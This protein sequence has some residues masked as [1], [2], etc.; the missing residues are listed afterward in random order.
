MKAKN[1]WCKAAKAQKEFQISNF[2]FQIRH[3]IAFAPLRLCVRF[4]L[5]L[6]VFIAM[7]ALAAD[8]PAL[9]DEQIDA[10]VARGVDFLVSQQQTDGEIGT[11]QS[12]IATSGLS[13]LALLA[14]GNTP[15]VGRNGTVVRQLI[16]YLATIEPAD[17]YFGK[18]DGSR[19]YGQGIVTLALAEALGVETTEARR[20]R[21]VSVLNSS[22]KV[23]L[24]AQNVPKAQPFAGGWRYEPNSTDSDLSQAAWNAMALRACQNAGLPVPKSAVARAG[25]FVLRCYRAD[26]NGFT[27]QPGQGASACETAVGIFC[28]HVLDIH[29]NGEADGALKSLLATKG[30]PASPFTYYSLFYLTQAANQSGPPAWDAIWP[31]TSATLLRTQDPGGFWPVSDKELADKD[32]GKVYATAM[33]VLTLSVPYRLLPIDQR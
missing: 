17:G 30:D 27:Y 14:C 21:L 10:A 1:I 6:A 29:G 12:R 16:D 13:L 2:K 23:I 15:D 8:G 9:A 3:S 26:Q 11:G 24:S 19:M 31:G 28:L 18:L 25:E 5:L 4:V 32:S 20:D 33:A 22:L 7:P